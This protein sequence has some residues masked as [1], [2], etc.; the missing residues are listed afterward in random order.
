MT[1]PREQR[2]LQALVAVHTR[3]K[4]GSPE[5]VAARENHLAF[6]VEQHAREIVAQHRKLRPEQRARVQEILREVL[7]DFV[8]LPDDF[9]N[10]A[11]A[12]RFAEIYAKYTGRDPDKLGLSSSTV[13]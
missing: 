10:E 7:L 11:D 8:L 13:Q 12:D 1:V 3:F 6:Q 9:L 2:R 5:L 4:P